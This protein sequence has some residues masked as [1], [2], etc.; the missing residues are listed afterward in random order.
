[1]LLHSFQII[2]PF[3]LLA[4][5]ALR[6][7]ICLYRSVRVPNVLERPKYFYEKIDDCQFKNRLVTERSEH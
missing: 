1:M 3:V 2:F 7:T 5:C 4:H 6:H